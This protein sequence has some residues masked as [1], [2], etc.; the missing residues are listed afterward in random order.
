VFCEWLLQLAESLRDYAFAMVAELKRRG[1]EPHLV[2]GDSRGTTEAVARQLG[3]RV[4][5]PRFSRFRRP[6]SF[7]NGG[8]AT[9]WSLWL[10]TGAKIHTRRRSESSRRRSLQHCRHYS[11]CHG[12]D[13]PSVRG[14]CDALLH[15]CSREQLT[16]P[17]SHYPII[18][19]ICRTIDRSGTTQ[20]CENGTVIP[21]RA[22]LAPRRIPTVMYARLC[23][24]CGDIPF[25]LHWG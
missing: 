14:G 19:V 4:F 2:S 25:L 9:P 3:T 11:C 12:P 7:A 15:L 17:K 20:R 8:K 13:Q 5:A 18:A 22:S 16:A 1:I 21:S 6:K 23:L 24:S 10:A